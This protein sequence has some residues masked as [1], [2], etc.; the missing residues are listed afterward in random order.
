MPIV[1]SQIAQ[2]RNKKGWFALKTGLRAHLV[3]YI[4]L[5][6]FILGMAVSQSALSLVEFEP[7]HILSPRIVN[8]LVSLGTALVVF[9]IFISTIVFKRWSRRVMERGMLVAV[10]IL[11]ATALLLDKDILADIPVSPSFHLLLLAVFLTS[12]CLCSLYWVC[13]LAHTS[14]LSAT[15]FAFGS[16]VASQALSMGL[17]LLPLNIR[18]SL[19]ALLAVSQLALVVLVRNQAISDILPY[20]SDS[21]FNFVRINLPSRDFLITM[22][23]G[24]YCVALPFGMADAFFG[25]LGFVP[26]LPF[27]LL[28]LALL[29][30]AFVTWAALS[31]QGRESSYTTVF[32]IVVQL[33][34][35]LAIVLFAAF[36]A[37]LAAGA[38][39]ASLGSSL[40]WAF[41][42]FTTIAFI[43]HGWRQPMY[44]A[45]AGW[46][47]LTVPYDL[48]YLGA[49][50]LLDIPLEPFVVLTIMGLFLLVS[51]QVFF[52][53][54][55][56][57]SSSHSLDS[58]TADEIQP[59][60]SI[61]ALRDEQELSAERRRSLLEE[62]AAALG[63]MFTLTERETEIL[64]LFTLGY[65]QRKVAQELF[66]SVDTVHTYIKR[67]YRKTDF[68]SR[69]DI[70]DYIQKQL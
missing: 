66:L 21:F 17:G 23:V 42:W 1:G 13:Q 56:R 39:L 70:L 68:H 28:L 4:A 8:I 44:Y 36:P 14:M 29:T 67:I 27:D 6:P 50:A 18:G 3:P 45:T 55:F 31:W 10:I 59:L 37:V 15:L 51:S 9:L 25:S 30:L 24:V 47:A 65:T 35:G 12:A 62:K 19:F 34:L 20:S 63:K 16:I 33:L 54:L 60:Q 2:S 69:N 53:R 5:L 22:A 40:I 52:V 57:T 7:L 58:S 46:L 43:N 49:E 61:M 11:G 41:I 48:G 32:W 26:T 38:L 64:S